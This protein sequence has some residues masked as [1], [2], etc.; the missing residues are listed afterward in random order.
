[1]SIRKLFGYA[2]LET[3][4]QMNFM[5]DVYRNEWRLYKN[6]FIPCMK[7]KNKQRVGKH[8]EKIR[9]VYDTPTTPYQRVLS[10][11]EVSNHVKQELTTF[12]KTLNPAQLR[13]Q[14]ID[15]QRKFKKLLP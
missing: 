5:N 7:L 8:G 12:F 15:K 14:I 3:T 11:P 2:R 13:R 6:F 4:E 9:R 1:M 10:S